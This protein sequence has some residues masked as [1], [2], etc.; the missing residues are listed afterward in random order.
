MDV[1]T[2]NKKR[3]TGDLRVVSL[4]TGRTYEACRMAWSRKEGKVYQEVKKAFEAIIENRDKL[5]AK[6]N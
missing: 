1:N 2:I 3:V 6:N 4:M 5:I